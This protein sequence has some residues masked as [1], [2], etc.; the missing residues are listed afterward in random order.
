[1]FLTTT[2]L[3]IGF[4]LTKG[5]RDPGAP[6]LGLGAALVYACLG[7]VLFGGIVAFG[8]HLL[9]HSKL[10]RSFVF[11][12]SLVLGVMGLVVPESQRH[13]LSMVQASIG[14]LVGG[15]LLSFG[16]VGALGG[17]ILGILAERGAKG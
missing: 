17:L 5:H 11:C 13:G 6:D 12:T 14:G 2:L 4:A 3:L 7:G 8:F 15:F 16:L 9:V 10:A 1:M